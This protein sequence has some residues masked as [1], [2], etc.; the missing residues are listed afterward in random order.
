MLYDVAYRFVTAS[1]SNH[2]HVFLL[3]VQESCYEKQS[4]GV[5]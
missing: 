3:R 2:I 4:A 5:L 1:V